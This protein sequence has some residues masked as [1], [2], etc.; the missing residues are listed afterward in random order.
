MKSRVYFRV[1]ILF[2]ATLV[3]VFWG[4]NY[5]KGKNLFSSER[6]FFC[7][8]EKVGGLTK[9]SPVTVNGFQVGQV[10]NI[11]LS[12]EKPGRIQV[13]FSISY[14]SI[15]IPIGSSARI[16]SVDLMGTKGIAMD[17]SAQP[18]FYHPGDTLEGSIE[19]DIRD[20]VNAQMLPLKIKIESLMSSMDSVLTG[21]QLVFNEN[22]RNN[23]SESFS[24]I[25]QTLNNLESASK[26]LDE[27][28]KAESGRLT[29]LFSSVDTLSRGLLDRTNEM[30]S[31]ISN[32]NR[33]GDTLARIPLNEVVGT[34]H[35]VLDNLN[36]LAQKI[37]AGEGSL[38]K[39]IIN[40]SLYTAI[41][42]TNASLNRLI[43]DVRIHPGKY[44]RITLSDKSKSVYTSDDS[45]LSMALAGEGTSDYYVCLFQSPVQIG[46]DDPAIRGISGIQ[47]VQVGSVFYYFAY[48]NPR[49]EPC[50]KKLEKYRKQHPSAGIFTWVGGKWTR[51][52]L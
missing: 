25:N 14:P 24:S 15:K 49:I 2:L 34:F 51:L 13:K 38:G 28:V 1:G 19:G 50:L 52:N 6:S 10:R 42:A 4:L 35:E 32:M 36:L 27:Y 31:F 9:S 20:Q 33:F 22:N 11:R 5:L 18:L 45:E 46:I 48:Q 26:F 8:Y 41:L 37:S 16:Y 21:I 17:L 12:E 29:S 39:L 3:I 47:F 30:K 23:L 40:D 44:V 43:E 7:L